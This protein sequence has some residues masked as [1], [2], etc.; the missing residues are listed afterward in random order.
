MVNTTLLPLYLRE[1]ERV[2]VQQEAGWA[3]TGGKISF[4]TG[5]DTR[6]SSP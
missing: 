6:P 4:L 3:P 5:F 1:E 2:P